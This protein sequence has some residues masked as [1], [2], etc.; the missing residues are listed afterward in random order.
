MEK[1]MTLVLFCLLAIACGGGSGGLDDHDPDSPV[2]ETDDP[3]S[4]VM[5]TDDPDS[6]VIDRKESER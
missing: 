4:P 5:E 1:L 2:M 3:D 6:P